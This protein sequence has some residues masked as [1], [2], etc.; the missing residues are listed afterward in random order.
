MAKANDRIV[1]ILFIC[2]ESDDDVEVTAINYYRDR[3]HLIDTDP[4]PIAHTAGSASA[5][6]EVEL[7]ELLPPPSIIRLK[8]TFQA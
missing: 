6:H 1:E 4:H 8:P 5:T 3:Q 2:D 7:G